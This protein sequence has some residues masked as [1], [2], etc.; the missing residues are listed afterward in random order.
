[1]KS[2]LHYSTQ[3]IALSSALTVAQVYGQGFIEDSKATLNARNFYFERNF[4]SPG[5]PQNYAQEWTQGFILDLRSGYTQGTIGFGVDVL[6]KYAVKLD[7]GAGHYGALLLPKDDDGEPADSFG[8]LGA[9]I[10]AKY[11]ATELK[12]GEW[13]P[14]LPLVTADDFRALPQTFRGAQITSKEIKN[15]SVYGGEFTSTSLRNDSSME[16]LS[17]GNAQTDAFRFLGADYQLPVQKTTI[18]LSS[19]QL[20]D[21]YQQQYVGLVNRWEMGQGLSLNTN[22]AYFWG[23]DDGSAKAGR[24]DNKTVSALIGLT[25]YQH[26]FSVGLQ[27]VSGATGWMRIAG[28][29]GIYLANNTFNHAFDNPKEKSWQMRYDLNFAGY[30]VP[31]LTL[32]ARYVHGNNVKNGRVDN[33]SEWGRETELAYVIQS[34]ALRDLSVRWRNSS[35]RRDFNSTDYDENRVIVSYPIN[36][37]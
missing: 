25:V 15:L 26:T 33:G 9:A 34:G 8:R 28:T 17:F 13:M 18:R 5:A 29:G 1:M 6:G 31:G 35:V 22:L 14:N 20:K 21:I 11:S 37:F 4:T 3:F 12:A 16:D 24:L 36:I 19:G 23:K 30:G 32:M 7:G 27:D 10:K 2:K